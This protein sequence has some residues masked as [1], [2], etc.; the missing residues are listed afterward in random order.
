M[1]I[2]RLAC[3]SSTQSCSKAET[4]AGSTTQIGTFFIHLESGTAGTRAGL[5]VQTVTQSVTNRWMEREGSQRRLALLSSSQG[6]MR[7]VRAGGGARLLRTEW[8]PGPPIRARQGELEGVSLQ[9]NWQLLHPFKSSEGRQPLPRLA[10]RWPYQRHWR[11]AGQARSSAQTG[12]WLIQ[13]GRA[14]GCLG[15]CGRG[16]GNTWGLGV[17]LWWFLFPEVCHDPGAVATA[18][19]ETPWAGALHREKLALK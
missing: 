18:Q 11:A 17:S 5:S 4:R 2:G 7:R 12:T 1:S 15:T 6:Q 10:P 13:S 16:L 8:H 19:E 3:R 14:R 9:A